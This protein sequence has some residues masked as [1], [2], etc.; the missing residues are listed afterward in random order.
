MS[1]ARRAWTDEDIDIIPALNRAAIAARVRAV[2]CDNGMER[3]RL[4]ALADTIDA[5]RRV[6]T[7]L[8]EMGPR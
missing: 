3:I 2:D 7:Q 1:A 5:E 4:N 8:L 6:Q